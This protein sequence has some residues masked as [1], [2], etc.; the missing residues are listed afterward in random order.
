MHIFRITDDSGMSIVFVT[1]QGAR[2]AARERFKREYGP[3]R[4]DKVDIGRLSAGKICDVINE[5]NYEESHEI[6][7][8]YT[9]KDLWL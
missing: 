2:Q 9:P 5:G 7:D 1:E 6:L 4:I 3:I 8:Y